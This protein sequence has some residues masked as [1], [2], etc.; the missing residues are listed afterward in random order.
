MKVREIKIEEIKPAEYNPRKVSYKEYEKLKKSIET[1]GFVDPIIINLKNMKII[2][3]HQRFNILMDSYLGGSDEFS[4]LHMI[5]LGDVGWA[6]PNPNLEIKTESEEKAL[7]IAL[8]KISGQW[9]NEKLNQLI[10]DLSLENFKIELT[11]FDDLELEQLNLMED[12]EFVP[13]NLDDLED[14]QK[15]E[16]PKPIV[17]CPN[18]GCEF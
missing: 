3:G 9:D 17:H 2:G 4:T 5:E 6:F 12:L 1:F 10:N 16:K 8:N 11:G 15:V 18:C 14:T 13:D 7:N